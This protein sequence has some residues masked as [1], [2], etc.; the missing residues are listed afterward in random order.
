M[1]ISLAGLAGAARAGDVGTITAYL[2]GGGDPNVTDT[3][4]VTLLHLAAAFRRVAIADALI[5]AGADVNARDIEGRTPLYEALADWMPGGPGLVGGAFRV[6]A[7]ETPPDEAGAAVT[8]SVA[9]FTRARSLLCF[10]TPLGQAAN[11][12]NVTIMRRLL[13]AGAEVNGHGKYGSTPLIEA[14]NGAQPA[15]VEFLLAAG[16]D[17]NQAGDNGAT[18]LLRSIFGL[19]RWSPSPARL[20]AL[21]AIRERLLAAG[22][23]PNQRDRRDETPLSAAIVVVRPDLI[24][25]LVAAGADPNRRDEDGN[26]ALARVVRW[27]RMH[28]RAD[29]ELA[30]LARALLA[31]GADAGARNHAGKT[32]RELAMEAGYPL[33]AEALGG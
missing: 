27:T 21:D 24:A 22:A 8:T 29:G 9:D 19:A 25:T 6:P 32:A 16:A 11:S 28:Q 2:A 3:S 15:A 23:D 4:G 31:A 33:L 14:V 13:E 1:V 26:T 12:G 30:P 7:P 5:E 10:E 18:P 17:V 20:A